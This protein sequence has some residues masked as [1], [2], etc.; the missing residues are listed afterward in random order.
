MKENI[1]KCWK[2]MIFYHFEGSV[3]FGIFWPTSQNFQKV[4]QSHTESQ[5]FLYMSKIIKMVEL[6]L[7]DVFET[8][9]QRDFFNPFWLLYEF[10]TKISPCFC[11]QKLPPQ[12]KFRPIWGVSGGR[13][14]W[15]I[16]FL[17]TARLGLHS[18]QKSLVL[19]PIGEKLFNFQI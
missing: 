9:H 10:E 11:G 17:E 2:M 16:S 8:L 14:S 6:D 12:A 19:L 3:I 1:I 7:K 5:K 18:P 15:T 13:W 4:A